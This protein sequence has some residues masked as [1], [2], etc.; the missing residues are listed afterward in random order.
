MRKGPRRLIQISISSRFLTMNRKPIQIE[1]E[2][3]YGLDDDF[4]DDSEA[5]DEFMPDKVSTE[6]VGLYIN[7]GW[8]KY[9]ELDDDSKGTPHLTIFD[10]DFTQNF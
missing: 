8:L 3:E 5:N 10:S 2:D 9:I 1:P 6:L 4:N 7:I